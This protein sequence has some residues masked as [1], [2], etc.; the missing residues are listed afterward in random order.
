MVARALAVLHTCIYDAWAA[1]DPAALGT[2]LGSQL[3]RPAEERTLANKSAAISY[4]AYRA[5]VDLFPS[6]LA[7]FSTLMVSLGYDPAAPTT[8]P[9]LPSG[10][11]NL[12]AQAVLDFRHDDGANQL[13]DRHPGAYADYTGYSPVNS[14]DQITD[15]NRWQPLR[16]SDGRGGFVVQRY[17]APQW[18]GVSPFALT[19]GA[20]LRPAAPPRYPFGAYRVQA[21]QLL[22]LSANLTDRQKAIAEYWA[23]G[24]SS[25][26][27]P[28]HWCLFAQFVAQRDHLDLD[29]EVKLF[30]ILA[31]ALLDASIAAW[32]AKRAFD[33]VRPITAIHYLFQDKPIRA[34]GGPFQ[35]T[36]VMPGAAWQ[37][38]QPATVVTPPFPEYV[39]GHSTFSAA[40]AEILKRFTGSDTFGAS[41]TVPAGSSRIEPGAVPGTDV[42]LAWA[43]FSDA[44]GEAGLSR[45]YGGIHFEDGDL[46]G[47]MLGRQVAGQVWERAQAYITGG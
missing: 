32:D 5:L 19:S 27:P 29:D 4:S 26:L 3:R 34:W 42:I 37:P 39:S 13:G 20:Q 47:R 28:G 41:I 45:R 36:R 35:G 11:G 43:T 44:A 18:G 15:P 2:R 7:T 38:Y 16:V 1:Y 17:V 46:R 6:E 10:L 9:A 14:P 30:F 21:E 33:S 24:P 23:D 12:A 8:D 22:H 31:N 40:S 25:E